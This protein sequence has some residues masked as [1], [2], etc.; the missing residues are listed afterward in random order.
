VG[1]ILSYIATFLLGVLVSAWRSSYKDKEIDKRLDA[2]QKNFDKALRKAD[3]ELAK[4]GI[5][6]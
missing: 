5:W 4:L 2:L 3:E 6:G 1:T